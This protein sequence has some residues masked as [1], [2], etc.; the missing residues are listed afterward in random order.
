MAYENLKAAIKQAI[1][2]N[3]NQEITGNLLQSTLL[4]I[5][6]NIEETMTIYDV[7]AHNNGATFESLS[8]LLNSSDLSKLIPTSVQ[9]SGMSIRFVQSSDNKYVQYRY[10]LRYENTTAGNNAFKNTSNW[11]KTSIP[12]FELNE[13]SPVESNTL[14]KKIVYEAL[15]SSYSYQPQLTIGKVIYN[16]KTIDFNNISYT[17]YS[18]GRCYY[19]TCKPGQ[20]FIIKGIGLTKPRLYSFH[21]SDGEVLEL[22][23]AEYKGAEHNYKILV[24]PDNASYFVYNTLYYVSDCALYISGNFIGGYGNAIMDKIPMLPYCLY[25]SMVSSSLTENTLYKSITIEVSPGERLQMKVSSL[26]ANIRYSFGNY[27]GIFDMSA[28]K[29]KI[30]MNEISVPVNGVKYLRATLPISEESYIARRKYTDSKL[31][32]YVILKND[33][34]ILDDIDL[35]NYT[36][37]DSNETK[38]GGYVYMAS[39]V[40]ST[41]QEIKKGTKLHYI[42]N[43]GYKIAFI[44][45]GNYP[46]KISSNWLA[47]E[48]DITI[49]ADFDIKATYLLFAKSNGTDSISVSEVLANCKVSSYIQKRIS[50]LTSFQDEILLDRSKYFNVPMLKGCYFSAFGAKTLTAHTGYKTLR[51]K[52]YQGEKFIIHK[53]EVSPV[54]EQVDYCYYDINGTVI[55]REN[56]ETRIFEIGDNYITIPSNVYYMYV[57]LPISD[58]SYILMLKNGDNSIESIRYGENYNLLSTKEDWYNSLILDYSEEK[59]LYYDSNLTR[60]RNIP[61][62]IP[63]GTKIGYNINDGYKVNIKCAGNYPNKINSGWLTG[64]GVYKTQLYNNVIISFAKTDGTTAITVD[65]VFANCSIYIQSYNEQ[66]D[67]LEDRIGESK[68]YLIDCYLNKGR[69]VYSAHRGLRTVAPENSIPAYEAAGRAGFDFLNLAQLRQSADGTWYVMHDETIDRTTDGTGAI[70]NLT[71]EYLQTVHIDTG[72]NIERFSPEELVIPTLEKAIQIA[73]KYGMKL[74]FRIASIT[75]N[76]Y[77][78]DKAAWDSF[79]AIIRKYRCEGMLFGGNALT[80]LLPLHRDLGLDWCINYDVYSSEAVF[81][82]ITDYVNAGI[83]N[84]T[85]FTTSDILTDAHIAAAR[86]HGFKVMVHLASDNATKDQCLEWSNKGVDIIGGVVN[87]DLSKD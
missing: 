52:V 77:Q 27:D 54:S 65:E 44:I 29:P 63:I 66:V 67:V 1:K 55:P 51:L 13:I 38:W 81:Q 35:F 19:G 68:D 9:H 71:D 53:N 10:M 14:Y 30:G 86:E 25:S 74:Y 12:T 58:E 26:D 15:N 32:D 76:S 72:V 31:F 49:T 23:E 20:I 85:I 5:V 84:A 6:N 82:Q 61:L 22:C 28:I 37:F 56:G 21:N 87:Y 78:A 41:P 46:N 70:E 24:A 45:F 3:G 57:H 8:A 60:L 16:T 73:R 18:N 17:D 34:N 48:G 79:I 47:R 50:A 2:Q 7:S 43:D 40:C 69:V 39:R 36:P 75:G 42:I 11:Q 62:N 83:K 80:D 4:N 33:I 59:W 64:N